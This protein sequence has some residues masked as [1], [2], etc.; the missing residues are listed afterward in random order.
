MNFKKDYINYVLHSVIHSNLTAY[1]S[2]GGSNDYAVFRDNPVIRRILEKIITNN[3]I[4]ITTFLV[5]KTAGLELLFKYLLYI[6]DKI[7]KSQITIFNL[8]DNFDYDVQNLKKICGNIDKTLTDTVSKNIEK[9][10]TKEEPAKEIIQPKKSSSIKIDIEHEKEL[11]T[12][13]KDA[14]EEEHG[15][16]TEEN[17]EQGLTLIENTGG[18]SNENEVFELSDIEDSQ[19]RDDTP[20]DE[21]I[22]VMDKE[23]EVNAEDDDIIDE[24]KAQIE[25]HENEKSEEVFELEGIENE[26]DESSENEKTSSKEEDKIPLEIEVKERIYGDD[27][28]KQGEP[29]KEETVT[30]EAYLKFENRFFEDV[31]ILEMLFSYAKKETSQKTISKLSTRMLQSFMEII[32]ISNELA[33]LSRQLSFD[34]T[35]DIFFTINIY[36]T[37]AIGNPVLLTGERIKLLES[38]LSLVNSIIKDEDYL[39]YNVLVEKIE[40]LKEEL[41]RPMESIPENEPEEEP[42]EQKEIIREQK[43]E[44]GAGDEIKQNQETKDQKKEEIKTE[45]ERPKE[46]H[47]EEIIT[48]EPEQQQEFIQEQNNYVPAGDMDTVIF[49][50]KHFVIEFEKIFISIGTMGGEYSKFDAL[51]KINDMNYC[52]RMLAKTASASNMND[53]LKL[54]EVSYVFL[55]YVKDYRMDMAD[56]EIQQVV[57]YIIITFKIL[58][59]GR[60]TEDFNIFVE[61]LNTPVKIFTDTN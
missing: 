51:E 54:S 52:M 58:I 29:L 36:F 50:M 41:T 40:K 8:K 2:Q 15:E 25:E 22:D 14:D 37:K 56:R 20:D 42:E 27:E 34:L 26:I 21:I 57:K 31:K 16:E 30:K 61:Y 44:P 49:K 5:G 10:E 28:Q 24:E 18:E 1:G 13:K 45:K 12:P 35:A 47:S 6:S 59:K 39:N 53:V 33:D 46:T 60:K 7:D 38:S 11:M 32:E 17:E 55:K 3:D 4:F 9:P 43:T 48:S 19:E 23:I